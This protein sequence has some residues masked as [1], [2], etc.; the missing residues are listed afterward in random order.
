MSALHTQLEMMM[1][2]L[3]MALAMLDQVRKER[4]DWREKYL[5][6]AES[7]RRKA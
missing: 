2:H 5:L 6:L 4:D 1:S 3:K 7:V